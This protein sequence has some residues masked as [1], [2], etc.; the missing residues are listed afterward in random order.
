MTPPRSHSSKQLAAVAT[1]AIPVVMLSSLAMAGTAGAAP[2]KAEHPTKGS[3]G[4]VDGKK[5]LAAVQAR[6]SGQGSSIP[7]AVIA[8]TMPRVASTVKATTSQAAG[9]HTVAA[10]ETLSGIAASHGVSLESLLSSNGLNESDIIQPDQ[11]LTVAG[12]PATGATTSAASGGTHIVKPGETLSAI[13]AEHGVELSALFSLNGVGEDTVIHP[14]Q[15]IK[16]G[17]GAAVEAPSAPAAAEQAAGSY[18]IKAGDT[19]SSIAAEHNV[20]LAALAAANGT[21]ANGTIYAGKTL[22]IPGVSAASS[23]IVPLAPSSPAPAELPAD[24]RVPNTFL[25]YTYPDAVVDDANRNKAALLAAPTPAPGQM[26]EMV[27]NTAA[28]MGVD[29]ALV[30]AFAEQESSFNHQS[31]SPANAIG[32]MQVIPDAGDWAS[33]L[34][35]RKLNLLDP[36]DNVTAG[37]AIIRALHE[38]AATEDEAI[39]GYYQGQYSVS[40]NGLFQDS[41]NYVAGIKA[42]R[43]QYR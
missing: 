42:K 2:A 36:Q 20:Q 30:L 38:G 33:G 16:V 22:T 39:A 13:A 37:V 5:L 17:A 25:H 11:V 9:M 6:T 18:V 21:S 41:V 28:S 27:A 40:V 14:G 15:S 19:L 29:P 31:V 43:E 8:G 26:K 12:A 32:T 1:A 35:G 23:E 34:V 7:A 3:H 10:G 4:T 24:E